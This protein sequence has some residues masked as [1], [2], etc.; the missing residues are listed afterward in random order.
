VARILASSYEE[1]RKTD[2][3]DY[4]LEALHNSQITDV[5]LL[6]RRGP[7]Q[8]SFTNPELKELGE[9]Q[10]AD[11]IVY[12]EEIE[13]DPL[14]EAHVANNPDANVEKNLRTLGEYAKRTPS[15]K[16]KRIHVM[17][18]SSPV[19]VIGDGQCVTALKV[20][21]NKLVE[22]EGDL[23]AVPTEEFAIIPTGL[24]FR[25]IGYK[26][27]ALPD[28]PFEPKRG[29]IPNDHGRVVDADTKAVI[30]GE[31]AVGWIKRGPSGIIGTNKPDSVD[32]V[33]KL[34]EDLP[35]LPELDP[36]V[37]N[38]DAVEQLIRER[39]PNYVSYADWLLLDQLE[40]DNGLLQSRPRIKFSRVEDMLTAI[41]RVKA[42]T[43][44]D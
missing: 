37:A 31:Y 40:Q 34:I 21:K 39:K 16:R 2:I 19:E 10:E 36:A 25:S 30:T 35:V 5:Y 42:Q 3:A 1:L 7:A 11:V 22:V 6:G 14:S 28:V 8:A 27:V 26:G 24:I 41:Q 4:A 29:V 43:S 13:L 33:N 20:V 18:L 9:L 12:P 38:P 23:K 15:G 17:F 44:A 32:T